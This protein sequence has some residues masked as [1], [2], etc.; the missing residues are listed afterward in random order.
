MIEIPLPIALQS[1]Y[2]FN[3]DLSPARTDFVEGRYAISKSAQT[4]G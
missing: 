1:R 4:T 2:F 3:A